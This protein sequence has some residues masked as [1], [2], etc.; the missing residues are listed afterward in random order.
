MTAM[1]T[2]RIGSTTSNFNSLKSRLHNYRVSA[3]SMI[4]QQAALPT[5][6]S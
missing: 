4:D 1:A 6:T 5:M 2:D 3:T